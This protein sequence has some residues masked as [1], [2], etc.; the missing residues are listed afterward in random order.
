MKSRSLLVVSTTA[1][2]VL[3][4]MLFLVAGANKGSAQAQTDSNADPCVTPVDADA[5]FNESWDSECQSEN[6][7]R[8]FSRFYTFT[9]QNTARV[10]IT[11]SSKRDAYLYLMQ[12]AG[13]SGAVLH[14]NDDVRRSSTNSRIQET[15]QPGSYTIEATAYT[16]DTTGDFSLTV[17]G[18][19]NAASKPPTPTHTPTQTPTPA[20]PSTSP[21][22]GYTSLIVGDLHT[23]GLRTDGSVVCWGSDQYGQSSPPSDDKFT[24]I[25]AGEHHTCG[26]RADG[27]A[28]CWGSDQYGQSSS[29]SDDK[30]TSI[31]AGE[32]HTCGIRV[33]GS[34]VC[35]GSDQYEQSSPPS[36]DKLISIVAGE[37]HT[38]GLR[39]DGSVV[40]WGNDEYGQSS[41][42]SGDKFTSI[43]AGAY[44][45]CGIRADGSVVCWGNDQYGQ[46]SSPSGDKFT[47][48]VA[49]AYHT[50]GIRADGEAVCWGRNDQGQQPPTGTHTPTPTPAA[51]HTPTPTLQGSGAPSFTEFN[52]ASTE[53][54]R[55]AILNRATLC[56]Q[57]L[58]LRRDEFCVGKYLG[59]LVA[60]MPNGRG[61]IQ[62]GTVRSKAGR[63]ILLGWITFVRQGDVWV[64]THLDR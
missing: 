42:P 52:N 33:D 28:V 6:R 40:C 2:A 16:S 17:E 63:T 31:V 30:F 34:A 44:H 51:T 45:T 1:A 49:G 53:A 50:C 15:L 38:C 11:L 14:K 32:H 64:I 36:G 18:L 12:G 22:G 39:T 7:A 47:S 9:L 41:S 56:S 8:T 61:Y 29:P 46:S 59:F 62:Q 37:H 10:K 26:I 55:L 21:S 58:V 13:T 19:G 54:E 60:H 43:V 3:L 20:P 48:I 35:W 27:S 5:T 25:V 24:S 57:D 4:L 23:C